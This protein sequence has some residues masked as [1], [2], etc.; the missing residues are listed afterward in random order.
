MTA[1]QHFSAVVL[2][3]WIALAMPATLAFS[4]PPTSRA[5]T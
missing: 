2:G 5:P 3:A 4:S 1:K